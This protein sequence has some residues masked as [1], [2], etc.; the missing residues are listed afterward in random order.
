MDI[1]R[2]CQRRVDTARPEE[3]AFA[4]AQRMATRSVGS[5]V[6]VDGRGRPVGKLTDRD[7]ALRVIAAC[8][9]A[10]TTEVRDVMT[11]HAES[12]GASA[13]LADALA[14]MRAGGVRRLPVVDGDGTLAGVVSFDDVVACLARQFAAAGEFLEQ[15]MPE[16]IAAT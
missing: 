9:D 13:S 1:G 6:V 12:L 16:R 2:I 5:L 11:G 8:L 7:L 3:S 10:R 4:A 14:A 15:R